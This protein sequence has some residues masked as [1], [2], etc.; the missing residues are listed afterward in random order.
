MN[1]EVP[2]EFHEARNDLLDEFEGF[3][4]RKLFIFYVSGQ[5]SLIAK[6]SD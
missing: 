6:F 2:G 3:L 4:F 5:V 1:N